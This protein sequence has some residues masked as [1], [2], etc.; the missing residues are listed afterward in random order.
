MRK[1][2]TEIIKI[3][4]LIWSYCRPHKKHYESKSYAAPLKEM[5]G[6]AYDCVLAAAVLAAHIVV[7]SVIMVFLYVSKILALQSSMNHTI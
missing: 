3:V 7:L 2:S 6:Y 4:L 1:S 5:A